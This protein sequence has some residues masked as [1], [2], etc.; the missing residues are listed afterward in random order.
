MSVSQH[1]NANNEYFVHTEP[2]PNVVKTDTWSLFG[3]SENN[4]EK[5]L[6]VWERKVEIADVSYIFF[7]KIL[8]NKILIHSYRLR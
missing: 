4:L 2:I 1:K 6:K 8:H 7:N 5:E 3:T